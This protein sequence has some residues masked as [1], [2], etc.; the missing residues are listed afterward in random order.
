MKKILWAVPILA[1]VGL[2]VGIV[3]YK[4]LTPRIKNAPAPAHHLVILG[5]CNTIN[6]V[7]HLRRLIGSQYL[8]SRYPDFVG[9][10]S[11]A[12]AS[13]WVAFE[14][15]DVIYVDVGMRNLLHARGELCS[16]EE[17]SRCLRG[18]LLE[19][20]KAAPQARII[21][22]TI[23]PVDEDAQRKAP[24]VG[25]EIVYESELSAFNAIIRNLCT[26]HELE[27][28]DINAILVGKGTRDILN[29]S[30]GSHLNARGHEVSAGAIAR[31]ITETQR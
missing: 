31:Q 23:S 9:A 21:L 2:A 5:D 26:A 13:N 12:V 11:L 8:V 7:P 15:P 24:G 16:P 4:F 19:L 29:E 6:A 14:N 1:V 10:K 22:G 30:D 18:S 3:Y 25:R 20:R 27:L 28:V 17:F